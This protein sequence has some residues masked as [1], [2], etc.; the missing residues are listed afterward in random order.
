MQ[1]LYRLLEYNLICMYVPCHPVDLFMSPRAL[2][3]VSVPVRFHRKL[4]AKISGTMVMLA[5]HEQSEK[6]GKHH[7]QRRKGQVVSSTPLSIRHENAT[8][9]TTRNVNAWIRSC[10]KDDHR[11][12]QQGQSGNSLTADDHSV[13]LS[14]EPEVFQQNMNLGYSL[15]GSV[16][17]WASGYNADAERGELSVCL[18]TCQPAIPIRNQDLP[19]PDMPEKKSQNCQPDSQCLDDNDG[20]AETSC[21]QRRSPPMLAGIRQ[22]SAS[23]TEDGYPL[24][25]LEISMPVV[26]VMFRGLT[27]YM[28]LNEGLS[29]HR[30][31]LTA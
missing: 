29:L 16:V 10:R 4:M 17:Y 27:G 14:P 13:Q 11:H 19:V 9:S 8:L 26:A 15:Y 6:E 22:A 25:G 31:P 18:S 1:N 21:R 20:R 3:T 24:T 2:G 7:V 23:R 5:V 28:A 12:T 30:V